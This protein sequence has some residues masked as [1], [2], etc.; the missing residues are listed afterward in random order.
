MTC[1]V[2]TERQ[3]SGGDGSTTDLLEEMFPLQH[4]CGDEEVVLLPA[5]THT[6]TNTHKSVCAS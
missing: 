3:T 4:S 2:G 5:L 6:L 1:K